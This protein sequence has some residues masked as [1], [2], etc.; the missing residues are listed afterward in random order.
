MGCRPMRGTTRGSALA[1]FVVLLAVMIPLLFGIPMIGKLVDLRQTSVQAS[2]YVAWESTVTDAAQAPDDVQSRFFAEGE[3]PISTAP[4]T[5]ESNLLWGSDRVIGGAEESMPMQTRVAIDETR[6]SATP[7]ADAYANGVG[8]GAAHAMGELVKDVG[9]II[10]GFTGGDW[11]IEPNGLLS[12]GVSIDF[13]GNEWLEARTLL[14]RSV[15]MNDGWSAGDDG[16]AAK[17]ARTFVP[18]GAIEEH[19]VETVLTAAGLLPPFKELR[20]LDGAFGL[21]DM[22]PLP[23]SET[24][25]R[26]LREWEEVR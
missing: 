7:Y 23:P 16:H 18:T 14:E 4:T 9:G 10:D 15:I 19:H 8:H 26:P 3:A 2:R 6:A 12:G 21:V 24:G 11:D 17:R 20:R 13:E 22:E 25:V 1:E 5:P